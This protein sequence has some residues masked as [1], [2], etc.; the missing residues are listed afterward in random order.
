MAA[1]KLAAATTRNEYIREEYMYAMAREGGCWGLKSLVVHAALRRVG[2]A[3]GS[4]IKSCQMDSRDT[5]YLL[6]S[7]ATYF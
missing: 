5:S 4:G 3:P 1:A 7:C 6:V 2:D